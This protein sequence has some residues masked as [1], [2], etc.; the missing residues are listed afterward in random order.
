MRQ[1]EH[2]R[3]RDKRPEDTRVRRRRN[4]DRAEVSESV[5]ETI[6]REDSETYPAHGINVSAPWRPGE[7]WPQVR[8]ERARGQGWSGRPL[9][10][11]VYS[12]VIDL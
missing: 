6:V 11:P 10:G 7:A 8:R 9:T 12:P 5:R 3:V 1:R 2:A 4:E